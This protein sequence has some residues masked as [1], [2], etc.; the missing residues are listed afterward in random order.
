IDVSEM[1]PRETQA[2]V[3]DSGTTR[4]NEDASEQPLS[5][6]KDDTVKTPRRRQ[7][8]GT[9]PPAEGAAVNARYVPSAVRRE[10]YA[11]DGRRCAFVSAH[12]VRCRETTFLELHHVTPYAKNG[13]TTAENLRSTVELTTPL[14]PNETSDAP[15]WPG[16]PAATCVRRNA[17]EGVCWA[18][19]SSAERR[20][21]NESADI[22]SAREAQE[23]AGRLAYRGTV[24]FAV[25]DGARAQRD[26]VLRH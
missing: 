14:P 17:Q 16:V 10:V 20:G 12:G 18:I 2:D 4:A 5:T 23:Q 15:S 19:V 8:L 22:A 3:I 26:V 25:R 7:P 9:S 24:N 13:A 6:V 1:S 11:R 21:M